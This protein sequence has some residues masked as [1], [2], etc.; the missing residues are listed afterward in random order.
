MQPIRAKEFI[1]DGDPGSVAK[2]IDQEFAIP[3]AFVRD[4]EASAA[5]KCCFSE[6]SGGLNLHGG[7]HRDEAGAE[8]LRPY[9]A[10]S[11]V[12]LI[13]N[14]GV[15][16]G[17]ICLWMLAKEISYSGKG[18]RLEHIDGKPVAAIVYRRRIHV[19]NLFVRQA[20]GGERFEAGNETVQGFNIRRWTE[21]G[22]SLIAISDINADELQEFSSKFDA[23]LR[24][25]G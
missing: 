17:D 9:L 25:G 4:I 2:H 20:V 10:N 1:D 12:M 13:D 15:P 5:V 8:R 3:I 23:A 16:T 11:V 18:G 21:Q 19:V 22:L 7:A 6:K 24:A 14:P